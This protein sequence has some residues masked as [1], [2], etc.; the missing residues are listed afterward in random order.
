MENQLAGAVFGSEIER[1]WFLRFYYTVNASLFFLLP[2]IQTN[3]FS[4]IEQKS[5]NIIWGYT[6]REKDTFGDNHLW[7]TLSDFTLENARKF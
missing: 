4:K 3:C 7:V 2:Q 1:C 5:K 6:S